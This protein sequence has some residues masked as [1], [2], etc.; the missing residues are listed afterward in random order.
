MPRGRLQSGEHSPPDPFASL[1]GLDVHAFNFGGSCVKQPNGAASNGAAFVA[2]YQE[3][4]AAVFEMLR[5]EVRPEALLRRGELGPG[6]VPRRAQTLR[7][8]RLRR[9]SAG[10]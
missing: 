4:P 10:P 2:R 5:L 9:L 1:T 8:L 3:C 6:R 7:V